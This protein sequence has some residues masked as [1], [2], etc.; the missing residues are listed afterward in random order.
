MADA[1]G[2]FYNGA[3]PGRRTA[4]TP[5][6]L[7][8]NAGL[9]TISRVLP[10]GTS[11]VTTATYIVG[12]VPTGG[13]KV[14]AINFAGQ[15]AVTATTLTAEVKAI[16]ADGGTS[17]T[18]QSAATSIKLTTSNDDEAVAGALTATT[19][20]LTLV[21]GQVIEVVIT[22]DT[23]SAGPGDL[24]VQVEYFPVEDSESSNAISIGADIL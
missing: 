12:L 15:A 4:V 19:A 11:T 8:A 10:L 21:A 16:P 1:Y 7:S 3:K 17:V 20:N 2:T 18:L 22:A 24:L 23:C 5:N 13:G 6:S 14:T 9:R